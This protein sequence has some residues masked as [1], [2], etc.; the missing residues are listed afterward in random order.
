MHPPYCGVVA[1][2]YP[3]AYKIATI[4]GLHN[5]GLEGATHSCGDAESVFCLESVR[6][7]GLNR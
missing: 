2:L 4:Q 5:S 1:L 7:S 3:D 6:V